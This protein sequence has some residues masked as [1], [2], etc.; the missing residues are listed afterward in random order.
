MNRVMH[1]LTDLRGR[2]PGDIVD[3]LGE[4]LVVFSNGTLPDDVLL[5]AVRAR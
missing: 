1:L 2:P 4:S 5:V 3:R